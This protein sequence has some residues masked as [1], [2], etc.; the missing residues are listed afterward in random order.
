MKSIM[1]IEENDI[2]KKTS[3]NKDI[4]KGWDE[5]FKQAIANG[6][7][8]ENDIFESMKNAFDDSEW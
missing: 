7:T 4:R 1:K 3:T 6:D 2:D 8:P 5:A